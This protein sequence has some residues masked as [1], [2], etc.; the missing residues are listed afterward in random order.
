MDNEPD[1]DIN[2]SRTNAMKIETKTYLEKHNL[3]VYLEDAI[4]QFLSLSPENKIK[5]VE[6]FKEYFGHV[7]KGTHILYREYPFITA[8]LYNRLCVIK[9]VMKIFKP[10]LNREQKLNVK[11]YHSLLQLVWCDI[12]FAVVQSAFDTSVK[13]KKEEALSFLE[14]LKVLKDSFCVGEFCP[15]AKT[16][17]SEVNKK[18]RKVLLAVRE[19]E[20]FEESRS[21]DDVIHLETEFEKSFACC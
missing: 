8:T 4:E 2:R 20:S 12:P 17:N 9:C 16:V 3:H 15:K 11:E 1:N 14:F 21:E 7:H 6:F 10:L 19:S 5:P 18:Y 13:Q